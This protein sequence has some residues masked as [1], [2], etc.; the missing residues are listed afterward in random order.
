MNPMFIMAAAQGFQALGNY[1]AAKQQA[2]DMQR[3]AQARRADAKNVRYLGGLNSD[4]A[5]R[6]GKALAG[7][8]RV[9][10]AANG[11]DLSSGT[12]SDILTQTAGLSELDARTIENNAM[13]QAWGM[14]VEADQ[15]DYQAKLAKKNAKIGLFGSILGAATSAGQGYMDWQKGKMPGGASFANMP[16]AGFDQSQLSYY[17]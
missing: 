7:S 14:D 5:R 10:L 8:Q 2:R 16:N 12:P 13:R 3:N 6:Q 9:A 17:G 4:V 11:V 15:M 1:R